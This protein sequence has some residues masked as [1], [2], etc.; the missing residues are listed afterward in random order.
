MKK[1][2][3]ALTLAILTVFCA[4]NLSGCKVVSKISD[5]YKAK[6]LSVRGLNGLKK[7]DYDYVYHDNIMCTIY[8]NIEYNTFEEYAS[9][10]FEFLT[11]RYS[12]VGVGGNALF[13]SFFGGAGSLVFIACEK[14][15]QNYK[16]VDGEVVSYN[17]IY[18]KKNP[19]EFVPT[20]G[21]YPY[22]ETGEHVTLTYVPNGRVRVGED[23]YKNYN[24]KMSIKKQ[25]LNDKYDWMGYNLNR[26]FTQHQTVGD[27]IEQSYALALRSTDDVEEFLQSERYSES[28]GVNKIYTEQS[29][30]K[31]DNEFFKH[32]SL[33]VF[34]RS[35]Y[36]GQVIKVDYYVEEERGEGV[37]IRLNR[38][39]PTSEQQVKL[40]FILEVPE[41]LSIFYSVY[42]NSN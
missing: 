37:T 31:Y 4:F 25:G 10:V 6:A 24:F 39:P 9:Y 16:T 12:H 17:F 19:E 36:Q 23:K 41:P 2:I 40:H 33:I 28:C 8:G 18:Y 3:L 5:F 14:Q 35:A 7:P 1:R 11:N 21:E 34:S 38:E 32:N 13:N 29:F 30:A 20:E 22:A 27:F 15:L 26:E 42:I